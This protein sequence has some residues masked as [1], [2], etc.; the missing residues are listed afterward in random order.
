VTWR[1]Y[2]GELEHPR[3]RTEER[4]LPSFPGSIVEDLV[5]GVDNIPRA[6]LSALNWGQ[7]VGPA[8]FG[9]ADLVGVHTLKSF[10]GVQTVYQMRKSSA[11]AN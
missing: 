9:N 10:G 8:A 11:M 4:A 7:E 5:L 1:A 2:A 3:V 6:K